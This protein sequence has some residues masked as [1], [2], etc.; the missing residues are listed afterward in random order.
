MKKSETDRSGA[1]LLSDLT[2]QKAHEVV[3]I[4]VSKE[5]KLHTTH[6]RYFETLKQLINALPAG[7]R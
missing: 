1:R 5:G 6:R 4:E 2:L 7:V 3:L